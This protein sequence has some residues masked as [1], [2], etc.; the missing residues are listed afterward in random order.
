MRFSFKVFCALLLTVMAVLFA[1]NGGWRGLLICIAL[2]CVACAFFIENRLWESVVHLVG[3]LSL[4]AICF[5]SGLDYFFGNAHYVPDKCSGHR[6]GLCQFINMVLQAGGPYFVGLLWV[7]VAAG[8]FLFSLKAFSY[9]WKR[10][11]IS[12]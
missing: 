3:G 2:L 8:L 6:P 7:C 5:H 1:F 11:Q 10:R 12:R 4:G 9:M